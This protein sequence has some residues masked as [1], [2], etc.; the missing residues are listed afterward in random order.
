MHIDLI[1]KKLLLDEARTLYH[2]PFT[3]SVL[4]RDFDVKGG[5]WSIQDGWLTG[6]NPDNAAGMIVSRQD[7]FG[8]ILID[9]KARTVP[10][11]THDISVM[12][13]GSWDEAS[14]TRGTAYVMG[15][16]GWWDGKV[17]FEKSPDYSLNVATQ[18]FPIVPGQ[19]YHIIAGSVGGHLF[20]IIDG[21]LVLEATDPDPI[22]PDVFGKIG[23][24]AYC[25]H[26]QFAD[27]FVRTAPY[28]LQEKSYTPEF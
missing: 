27:L 2:E 26:I 23:F 13:H 8:D 12:W 10:P 18:I 19:I 6:K 11:C 5:E 3:D 7:F 28:V 15:V 22:H 24:E 14:N 21:K 16:Q 17:G 20:G 4:A 9:V 1:G 25:S